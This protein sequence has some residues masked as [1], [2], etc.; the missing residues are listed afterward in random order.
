MFNQ[1]QPE[2]IG[3]VLDTSVIIAGHRSLRGASN[4]ILRLWREKQSFQIVVSD[5]ILIEWTR[6]LFEQN[7]PER[8][9]EDFSVILQR[10]ALLTSNSY[11]VYRIQTDPSDNMFLAAA[12]EGRADYVVS[13]D[14][15]LLELKHYHRIQIVRPNRFLEVLRAK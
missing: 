11:I 2:K 1:R 7:V 13:L 8:T 9:I 14:R 15:H 6:V 4:E 5:S 10:Q 3:A 12:L